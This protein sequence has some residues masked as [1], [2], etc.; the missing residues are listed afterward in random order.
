LTGPGRPKRSPILAIRLITW[1][2]VYLVLAGGIYPALYESQLPHD[3]LFVGGP[4][5]ANW[6]NHPH[7][8]PLFVLLGAPAGSS[9]ASDDDAPFVPIVA[10]HPDVPGRVV[11]VYP[12][13]PGVVLSILTVTLLA[14]VLGTVAA[15]QLTLRIQFLRSR[16]P[17]VLSDGPAPPPPRLA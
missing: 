2:L 8:N 10:D 11:S 5:P 1:L 14:T 12:G 6:E 15:P 13:V 16:W 3:H 9:A 4:P 7:E 17:M